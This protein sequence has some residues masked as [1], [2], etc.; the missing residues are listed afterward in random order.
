M[1]KRN[2]LNFYRSLESF[3]IRSSLSTTPLPL[4][5]VY[6]SRDWPNRLA[7]RRMVTLSKQAQF[8]LLEGVG[9]EVNVIAPD[10]LVQVIRQFVESIQN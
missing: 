5:V 7:A 6:G 2:I 3:D 1:D 8:Y 9:H 10:Q 4:A